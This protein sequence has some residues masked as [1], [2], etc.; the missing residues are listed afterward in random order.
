VLLTGLGYVGVAARDID[1]WSTF[2]TRLLGMQASESIASLRS[3]RMDDRAQRLFVER[4]D[5]D[6]VLVYGWEA[7]D[8][9]AL[10]RIAA[11]VE[12]ARVDVRLEPSSLAD[13]RCVSEVVSFADPLG[14]RIEVFHGAEVALAPFA[15]GRSISGFRTG[16]LGLGHA[17]LA[18]ERIDAVLPFYRDVLGFRV[19]DFMLAPFKAYFLHTNRR[20][21]SLA[22]IE[23]GRNGVHHLMVELYSLDDVGQAY[24]LALAEPARVG[25]T[26]GRH[27]NDY[28]TSFYAKSPSGFMIEYG[29]GGRDVDP[30]RW[31]PRE[32][33]E[34][35]SLWGHDRYW[36][37]AEDRQRARSLCVD[38]AARG[39][40][41]P[42]QVMA[43]NYNVS[44]DRC[45]WPDEP[46]LARDD[47]LPPTG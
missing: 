14:N 47:G 11:R 39:N 3:F 43:G 9:E 6:G 45:P 2:A 46:G 21:H 37:S 40:R 24:D 38:A 44:S 41:H 25:V 18:V 23:N 34:G 15:P 31:T 22:L 4:A 12:G 17:V 16:A 7:A 35:P 28:M 19:S 5:A 1:A 33:T 20:H 13:R 8:K 42:V 10:H 32:L 26:L 30:L 36:L 29:W 27:S